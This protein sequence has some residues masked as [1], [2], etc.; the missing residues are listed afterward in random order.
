MRDI[1]EV[2]IVDGCRTAVGSIGDTLKNVPADK[3]A[4]VC[5]RGLL[6]R[7]GIKPEVVEEVIMGQCRQSSDEPNVARIAALRCFTCSSMS[8]IPSTI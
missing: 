2:V 1:K 5:I 4:E 8:V 6:D 7:T 3:L